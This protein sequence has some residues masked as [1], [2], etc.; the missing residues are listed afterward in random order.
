MQTS[1]VHIVERMAPGGIESLVLDLI[2]NDP[3]AAV[4]SLQ[5]VPGEL[6]AAWPRLTQFSGSLETFSRKPGFNPSLTV[7]LAR[8]LR[9]RAPRA[10]FMHH[11]GPL[12]YGGLAARMARVPLLFYVEHDSWHYANQS[13]RRI[14]RVVQG[15]VR[16]KLIAVARSVA[17]E[18]ELI[19]GKRSVTV[20]PPGVELDKFHPGDRNAA[21]LQLGLSAHWKIV[22][23][24]G[25]LVAVK[26]LD[27]AI[28]AVARMETNAHLVIV[29]DGPE[30]SRLQGLAIAEGIEARVHF[31]GHRENLP[32]IYPAFDVFCLTSHAEGLPRSLLEAQACSVPVVTT[33]AGGIAEGICPDSGVIV[34]DRCP[35]RLAAALQDVMQRSLRKD[36]RLH[37]QNN[38]SWEHTA[39]KFRA[40]VEAA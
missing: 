30:L 13:H 12:F 32:A 34:A 5:G 26:G 11:M 9:R 14:L 33:N 40:L 39:A 21:R 28:K 37:M 7:Q 8:A 35:A 20:I 31:L 16:P 17:D 1:S 27:L 22:G 36:P 6:C 18:M 4:F 24:A 25:R 29:G 15:L 10:V 38:L 2:D 23:F 19:V 3:A